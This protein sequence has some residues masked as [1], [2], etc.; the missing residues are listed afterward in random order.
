MKRFVLV[1][2][3]EDCVLLLSFAVV[4][5][6]VMA[7]DTTAERS[8]D[9]EAPAPGEKVTVTTTDLDELAKLNFTN[10]FDSAFASA[11]LIPVTVDGLEHR[12][13]QR[14]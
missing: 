12:L 14:R 4:L 13:R 5:S 10:E 2:P 8:L 1:T 3:V 6:S 7:Q 11:E 9:S